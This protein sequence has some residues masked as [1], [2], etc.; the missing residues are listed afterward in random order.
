LP[1]NQKGTWINN[2]KTLFDDFKYG[3]VP[4]T[5]HSLMKYV[6]QEQLDVIV[7]MSKTECS[8]SPQ[9]NCSYFAKKVW[10]KVF[11]DNLHNGLI[12]N[13]DDLSKSMAKRADCKIAEPLLVQRP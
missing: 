3:Y 5:Q 11:N 10:N 12:N 13:P 1:D 4:E 7:S 8:W 2:E 6:T 9:N